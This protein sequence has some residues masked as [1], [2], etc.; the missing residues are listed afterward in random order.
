MCCVCSEASL[1]V[2]T[3]SVRRDEQFLLVVLV[4]EDVL[5]HREHERL[6]EQWSLTLAVASCPVQWHEC[7]RAIMRKMYT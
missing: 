3:R 4:F 1:Q 6:E 5:H 2:V 7:M